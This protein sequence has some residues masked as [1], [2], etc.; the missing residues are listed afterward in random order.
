MLK[1]SNFLWVKFHN[2][3]VPVMRFSPLKSTVT[4]GP[5]FLSA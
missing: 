5:V 2:F 3:P 1:T 4:F